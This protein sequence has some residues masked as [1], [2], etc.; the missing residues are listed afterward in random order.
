MTKSNLFTPID[1]VIVE[2]KKRQNSIG[3]DLP[4]S[5]TEKNEGIVLSDKSYLSKQIKEQGY[6]EDPNFKKNFQKGCLI[7]FTEGYE[8]GDNLMFVRFDKII[9]IF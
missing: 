7:K 2:I 3:L 1:G 5:S 6:H 8:L 9:G 4:D